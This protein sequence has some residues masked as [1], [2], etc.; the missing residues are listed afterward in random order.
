MEKT[1]RTGKIFVTGK[2]Y[3]EVEYDVCSNEAHVTFD[4]KGGITYSTIYNQSGG[5]FKDVRL[6]VLINGEKLDPFC[7]KRVKLA[8]RMITPLRRRQ[9]FD[10]SAH[11]TQRATRF[12]LRIH[13]LLYEDALGLRRV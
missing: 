2:F 9:R 12:C 13:E 10:L 6:D 11:Q 8:G 1:C 5:F 4:G 7:E 3:E